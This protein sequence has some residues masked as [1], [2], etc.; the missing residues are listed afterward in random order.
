MKKLILSLLV[1]G[2]SFSIG[3]DKFAH[4]GLAYLA[5]DF[6]QK[7]MQVVITKDKVY[8]NDVSLVFTGFACLAK[9]A[10]FDS[11]FDSTDLAVGIAGAGL[12]WLSNGGK[13]PC[14]KQ[15]LSNRQR[16]LNQRHG[17]MGNLKRVRNEK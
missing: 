17:K 1:L 12:A 10:I 14:V 5:Q 11:T 16:I 4:F 3:I 7:T 2:L 15:K 8:A 6:G 13:M 9:E